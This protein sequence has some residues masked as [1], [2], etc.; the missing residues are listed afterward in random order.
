MRLL[1]ALRNPKFALTAHYCRCV[2]PLDL[3]PT[4]PMSTT[5]GPGVEQQSLCSIKQTQ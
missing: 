1:A 4:V 3:Q 5:T 2:H